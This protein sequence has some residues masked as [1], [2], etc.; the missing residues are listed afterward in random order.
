MPSYNLTYVYQAVD[1]FTQTAKR[2]NKIVNKNEKTVKRYN[3]AMRVNADRMKLFGSAATKYMTLPLLA[4][5]AGALLSASKIE[6]LETS[7]IGILG[8]VSKARDLVSQLNDFSAKTPFQ[9]EDVANSAKMILPFMKPKEVLKTLNMV[10]DIAAASGKSIKDVMLPV[11]KALGKGKVQ[12]EIFEMIGEKGI[13]ILQVMAKQFGITTAEVQKLGEKGKISTVHLL[14]ALEIMT[15]KG[16]YAYRGMILQSKTFGGIISTLRDVLMLTA[17][18][19]GNVMLPYAK[20]FG[21]FLTDF[22]LKVKEFAKQNP[23]IVKFG[24]VFAGIL[25]T[26]GPIALALGSM[27]GSILAIKAAMASTV[28]AQLFTGSA[29]VGVASIAATILL[30]VLAF[31]ALINTFRL[32]YEARHD[33]KY[34]WDKMGTVGHWVVAAPIMLVV[35]AFKA[36]IN[37]FRLLPAAWE[38]IKYIWDKFKKIKFIA[39]TITVL[40]SAIEALVSVMQIAGDIFDQMFSNIPD[41]A[42]LGLGMGKMAEFATGP[43]MTAEEY[44]NNADSLKFNAKFEFKDPGK[45]LKEYYTSAKVSKGGL[46]KSVSEVGGG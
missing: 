2:I 44:K 17:A 34:V 16:G 13:P 38:N 19:F 8:N 14:K 26:I 24:L 1:R 43:K 22:L 37:T 33:I 25:A 39:D 46:G 18:E 42:S 36:L 45:F 15:S 20:K 30:V 9:L 10:G 3:K 40:T 11:M 32:L 27:V 7:F 23:E 5:G 29:A 6:R 12:G 21:I 31:A 4:V 41:I 28:V 35:T